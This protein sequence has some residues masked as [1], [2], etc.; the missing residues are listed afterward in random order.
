MPCILLFFFFSVVDPRNLLLKVLYLCSACFFSPFSHSLTHL[1][2]M[3]FACKTHQTRWKWDLVWGLVHC[4]LI[5]SS[6]A[7]CSLWRVGS[8]RFMVDSVEIALY[9]KEQWTYSQHGIRS[10]TQLIDRGHIIHCGVYTQILLPASSI[11]V[12]SISNDCWCCSCLRCCCCCQY[13][14]TQSP[15]NHKPFC[16]RYFSLR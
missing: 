11:N 16:E 15:Y 1:L 7:A 8:W 10:L 2:L 5:W 14:A 6:L 13:K 4:F 3:H 9:I 12:L